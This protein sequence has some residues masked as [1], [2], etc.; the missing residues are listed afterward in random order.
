MESAIQIQDLNKTF[1]GKRVLHNIQFSIQKGDFVSLLGPSGCGKTTLLRLVAGFE[2]PSS[3]SVQTSS[4]KKSFV[5]Q[6][7]GL[8]PW[9]T[10]KENALLPFRLQ[11]TKP[12]PKIFEELLELLQLKNAL[13]LFPHE[14]SGG[15]KMRVSL[16]RA[17][18]TDP[19]LLLLDEPFSALDEVIRIQLQEALF[20]FWLQKRM[21]VL[22]VTHSLSE[23]VLLSQKIM[24]MNFQGEIA[25]TFPNVHE[26]FIFPLSR[27]Q[28]QIVHD[29]FANF[30]RTAPL[31]KADAL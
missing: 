25:K 17:L 2:K 20:K 23:A 16:L 1:S 5:F 3:G 28:T 24:M 22:F 14:L 30:P 9:L 18:L 12:D 4:Q 21:T 13:S 27:T 19:D 31:I 6:D 15:M 7:A 29:L 10:A 11:K 8:L 26:K